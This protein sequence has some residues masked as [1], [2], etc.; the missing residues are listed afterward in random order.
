M[1]DLLAYLNPV[2][3]ADAVHAADARH[4]EDGV[5]ARVSKKS[6]KALVKRVV[7]RPDVQQYFPWS[8]ILKKQT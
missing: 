7:D 3:P 4:M 1:G 8:P 6:R 5:R 2:L